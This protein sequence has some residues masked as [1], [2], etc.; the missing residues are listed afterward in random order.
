MFLVHVHQLQNV[1]PV[2]RYGITAASKEVDH[3]LQAPAEPLGLQ[4]PR[5]QCGDLALQDLQRRAARPVQRRLDVRQRAGEPLERL[6]AMQPDQV[7]P[8]VQARAARRALG[9]RQQPDRVV[10]M[11]GP[12][13]QACLLRQFTNLQSHVSSLVGANHET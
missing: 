7:V 9:R 2:V 12:N 1:Q 11:Q 4:H 6:D 10:V 13:A 5:V 3:V 8:A